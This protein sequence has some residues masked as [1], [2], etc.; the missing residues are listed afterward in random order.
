MSWQIDN[1]FVCPDLSKAESQTIQKQSHFTFW[2][3][4][5]LMTSLRQSAA[6]SVDY[7]CPG[8]RNRC[9]RNIQYSSKTS[10]ALHPQHHYHQLLTV[11]LVIVFLSKCTVLD[12]QQLSWAGG[13]RLCSHSNMPKH[14]KGTN[15]RFCRHS[16]TNPLNTHRSAATATNI[17]RLFVAT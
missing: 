13:A 1:F 4:F 17:V 8:P 15:A 11:W 3:C 16:N 10:M 5:L 2:M 9:T 7:T 12:S 14:Q 6:D